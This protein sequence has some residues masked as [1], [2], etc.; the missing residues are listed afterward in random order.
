VEDAMRLMQPRRNLHR[1]DDALLLT[2]LEHDAE[3]L[4]Q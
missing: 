2:H 3:R 1:R 4:Y